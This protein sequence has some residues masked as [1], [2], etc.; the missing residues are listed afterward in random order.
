ML[1]AARALGLA[2]PGQ[3]SVV[4][5][6][7]VPAAAHAVPPLTTVRQPFLAK[8]RRAARLLTAGETPATTTVLPVRLIERAS[9]APPDPP[10]W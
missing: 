7:D 6:D 9:T 1:Q 2:V 4:G 5:T 10:V 3:L 8:G